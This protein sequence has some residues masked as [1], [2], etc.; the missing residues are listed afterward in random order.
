M[1]L[2][3]ATKQHALTRGRLGCIGEVATV[4][5]ARGCAGACVFCY[6]RC[7][8]GAPP[9]NEL[10]LYNELPGQLRR[11]LDARQRRGRMPGFV[12]FSTASDPFLGGAE[13]VETARACLEVL[14]R[15]G[16]GVVLS[17]RGVPPAD[18]ITLLATRAK[19]V[20]ITVPLASLD[21]GY[22]RGWEPGTAPP[23]ER[24]FLLQRLQ[25]A[26]LDPEV[27]I[28]PLTSF[29]N[30]ETADLRRLCSALARLGIE[31]VMLRILQ[32]RP[33]V[34]DQL[35]REVP[36][37]LHR[38]VLGGFPSL[39]ADETTDPYDHLRQDLALALLRRIQRIGREHGLRV[40]AC[41]CQNPGLPAGTCRV[42]PLQTAAAGQPEL[43][44]ENRE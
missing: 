36:K 1:E 39:L 23:A 24:L 2:F 16:V 18:V 38:L 28:E 7:Y 21:E 3:A 4:N 43:F 26:G 44:E 31:R 13:V 20:R 30:D 14:V 12:L 34:A 40:S 27:R 25:D 17:T 11:E 32:L 22:W 37:T 15:R 19:Q 41:R 8:P 35:R 9:P 6:A 5:I 42:R 29:V 10:W 33:G